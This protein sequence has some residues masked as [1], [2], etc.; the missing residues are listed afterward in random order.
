MSKPH[1][2]LELYLSYKASTKLA[3]QWLWSTSP[4]SQQKS[5]NRHF[6]NSAEIVKAASD[7]RSRSDNVPPYVI[8]AL[9]DAIAKRWEVYNLYS[10]LKD[11]L[12]GSATTAGNE[13]HR[14]FI[15]RSVK[16]RLWECVTKFYFQAGTSTSASDT[17]PKDF[18]EEQWAITCSRES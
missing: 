17:S 4:L 5:V 16:S 1:G 12:D 2:L 3:L 15:K 9:K 6:S 13:S 10:N 8:S 7:V 14:A 11:A 18:S